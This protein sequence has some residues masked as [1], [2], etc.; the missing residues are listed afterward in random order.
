VASHAELLTARTR[1]FAVRVLRF[2]MALPQDPRTNAILHR[3]I[4]ASASASANYRASRRARSHQERVARLAIVAEQTDETDHWLD[5]LKTTGMI[6][7][8]AARQELETLHVESS[9][10]RA[11]FVALA[12]AASVDDDEMMS[13]AMRSTIDCKPP[14][15]DL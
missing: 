10:L 7:G 12:Q 15:S 2:I 14:R 5:L 1:E 9:E 8:D 13:G 4:D 11:I 3:L 6:R